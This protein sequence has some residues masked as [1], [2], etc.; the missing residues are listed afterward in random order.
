M[1]NDVTDFKILEF[2]VWLLGEGAP[3]YSLPYVSISRL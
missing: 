2:L 3:R 1:G